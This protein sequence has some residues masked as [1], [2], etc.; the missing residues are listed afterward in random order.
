MKDWD[1]ERMSKYF[2]ITGLMKLTN[3]TIQT[4]K[5]KPMKKKI[6]ITKPKVKFSRKAVLVRRVLP[7]PRPNFSKKIK[8][9]DIARA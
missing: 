6:I 9:S 2:D 3:D 7:I 8:T 5:A 4:E 1:K